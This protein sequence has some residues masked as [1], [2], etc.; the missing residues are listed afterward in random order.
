MSVYN[1]LASRIMTN[2]QGT[3]I[4][5][6]TDVCFNF[7]PKES[8]SNKNLTDY[9]KSPSPSLPIVLKK[10]QKKRV[11]MYIKTIPKNHNL[12]TAASLV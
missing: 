2:L 3:Y 8:K 12:T 1:S 4:R 6:V 9:G 5:L 10:K 7:I 11:F